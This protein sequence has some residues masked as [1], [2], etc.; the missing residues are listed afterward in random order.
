MKYDVDI[1]YQKSCMAGTKNRWTV[2]F[3]NFDYGECFSY[4][5][6]P[7]KRQIRKARKSM[8]SW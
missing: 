6:K 3:S 2:V 8:P 1:D 7:T 5:V 4:P